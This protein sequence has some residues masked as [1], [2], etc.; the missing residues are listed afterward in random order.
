MS[1]FP[2]ASLTIR[3]A[4]C[5]RRPAAVVPRAMSRGHFAVAGIA[6]QAQGLACLSLAPWSHTIFDVVESFK[7]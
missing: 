1:C 3:V 6:D 2:T 7:R 4:G 5:I